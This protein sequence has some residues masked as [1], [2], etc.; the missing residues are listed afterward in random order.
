MEHCP[1][2]RQTFLFSATLD[3]DIQKL[4]GRFMHDPD[5][6]LVKSL[7]LTVPLTQQYYLEVSPRHKIETF[8]R[9]M[10]VDQPTVSLVFCRTKKRC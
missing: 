4:G 9:I 10:D 7:E 5:I 8:C 1:S 3:G 2:E 6:I